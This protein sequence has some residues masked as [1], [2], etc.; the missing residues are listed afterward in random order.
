MVLG[1][2]V[3]LFLDIFFTQPELL[4]EYCDPEITLH[5]RGEP[6]IEGLKNLQSFSQQQMMCFKDFLFKIE[7]CLEQGD[8]VAVRLTQTGRLKSQWEGCD[9]IGASFEV[10]ETMFFQFKDQKILHIWPLLDMDEKKRQLSTKQ[11]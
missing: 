6:L 1:K 8:K 7:D 5:W 10:A 11:G 4:D 9:K 2:Q 3:E